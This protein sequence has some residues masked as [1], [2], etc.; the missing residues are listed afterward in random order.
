MYMAENSYNGDIVTGFLIDIQGEYC[1]IK[2]I[3]TSKAFRCDLGSLKKFDT[4]E[5]KKKE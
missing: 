1:F 2:P 3:G 5:R 4:R